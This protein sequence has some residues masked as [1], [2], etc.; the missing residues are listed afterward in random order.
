VRGAKSPTRFDS[1][2]ATGEPQ[3]CVRR[4]RPGAKSPPRGFL[5]VPPRRQGFVAS[6][7]RPGGNI[8]GLGHWEA[9]MGGKWLELLKE[10]APDVEHVAVVFNPVTAPYFRLFLP[11]M[12]AAA[13]SLAVT[14]TESPVHEAAE[15]ER[16]SG[17][18]RAT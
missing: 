4:G 12:E 16:A 14:L 8:T 5:R 13:R 18:R 10:I 15:I 7:A 3:G 2:P 6:L 11:T 1:Q 17:S 9:G